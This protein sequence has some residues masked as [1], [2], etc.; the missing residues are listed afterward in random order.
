MGWKDYIDN[1][2]VL[3]ITTSHEYLDDQE[4]RR[5][6]GRTPRVLDAATGRYVRMDGC[7]TGV[8]T[9]P[10]CGVSRAVTRLE[11]TRAVKPKCLKCGALVQRSITAEKRERKK[12]LA[13]NTRNLELGHH[14]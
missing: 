1:D 9:N 7:D 3:E 12:Q 10:E 6:K 5:R 8:C 4:E 2:A 14:A 13:A 11:W